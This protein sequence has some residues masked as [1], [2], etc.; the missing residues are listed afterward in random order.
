I[1]PGGKILTAAHLV[2]AAARIEVQFADGTRSGARVLGSN[3]A[4]DVAVLQAAKAPRAIRP[5]RLGDS[6]RVDV[7]DR[8]IVV[9]APSDLSYSLSVGYVTGRRAAQRDP[10]PFSRMELF[11]TDA[12]VNPGNSG[13]PMVNEA[14]EVI[15]VMSHNISD[16]GG[17]QGLGFA[18]T[19]NFARKVL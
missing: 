13:G 19:S 10:G 12:A 3:Q 17:S 16:T 5:A 7:G 18:V 4:G 11:Q 6:D 2:Q 9:G 14:G 1:G 15:G 8:V